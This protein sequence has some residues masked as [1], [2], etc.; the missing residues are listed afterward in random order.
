V[1]CGLTSCVVA[2]CLLVAGVVMMN[3]S[4]YDDHRLSAERAY[5]FAVEQWVGGE[6]QAFNATTW[7]L[8]VGGTTI[9]FL[10]ET[11]VR[12]ACSLVWPKYSTL[13]SGSAGVSRRAGALLGVFGLCVA[14]HKLP[15]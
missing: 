4:H 3:V 10:P 1:R 15:P 11:T 8:V 14:L 2:T 6:G 5:N 9:P 7:E 13:P 12:A